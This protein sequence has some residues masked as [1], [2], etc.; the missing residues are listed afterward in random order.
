[1]SWHSR[2]DMRASESKPAHNQPHQP[3][4]GRRKSIFSHFFGGRKIIS[5]NFIGFSQIYLLQPNL[6]ASAN[7][8]GFSQLQ[9]TSA[10]ILSKAA[11][12]LS[13]ALMS[14]AVQIDYE[15]YKV[16]VKLSALWHWM[17]FKNNPHD[18][19]YIS[20]KHLP[21]HGLMPIILFYLLKKFS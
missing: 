11:D 18:K 8:I 2:S 7:F 6:L 3:L 20:H 17:F 10:S 19:T 15:N 1:M 4:M 14:A 13:T 9:P 5:A 16:K 21:W 12:D